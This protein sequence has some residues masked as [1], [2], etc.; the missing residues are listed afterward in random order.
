[1]GR[2]TL[3]ETARC[4]GEYAVCLACVHAPLTHDC[5]PLLLVP[6]AVLVV[7]CGAQSPNSPTALPL[8][9]ASTPSRLT[10]ET[11]AAP[12]MRKSKSTRTANRYLN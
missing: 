6:D 2:G 9:L 8:R 12:L 7:G 11:P 3:H 1:M 10:A 4:M 5:R